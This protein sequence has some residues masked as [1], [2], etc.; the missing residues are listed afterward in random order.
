M[1]TEYEQLAGPPQT[2]NLVGGNEWSAYLAA[3]NA[4]ASALS[5]TKYLVEDYEMPPA[6]EFA[7]A[8]DAPPNFGNANWNETHRARHIA[9]LKKWDAC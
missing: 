3:V 9:R 5:L 7:E 6:P 2:F 8:G 1:N 4:S